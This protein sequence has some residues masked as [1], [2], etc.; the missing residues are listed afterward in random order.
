MPRRKLHAQAKLA[1]FIVG[2]DD[3]LPAKPKIFSACFALDLQVC[4]GPMMAGFADH[5]SA[6]TVGTVPIRAR[7]DH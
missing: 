6:T 5:L 1:A 3:R 4:E 7:F 2:A